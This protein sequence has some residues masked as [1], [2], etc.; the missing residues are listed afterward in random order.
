MY[1]RGPAEDVDVVEDRLWALI[2]AVEQYVMANKTL[3]GAVSKAPA[4]PM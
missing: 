2:T 1:R 3:G 4:R